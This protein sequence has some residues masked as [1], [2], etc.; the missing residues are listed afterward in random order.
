MTTDNRDKDTV[1]FEHP[2]Y[3]DNLEYWHRCRVITQGSDAV[4]RGGETFLPRLKGQKGSMYEAYKG[5]AL[6]FEASARTVQGILGALCSKEPRLE[7]P[8]GNTDFFE[9][10]VPYQT[11]IKSFIKKVAEELIIVGRC[12]LFLDA[13][14]EGQPYLAFYEAESIINWR[15]I[16][17]DSNEI[18]T[19]VVLREEYD[20]PLQ[21]FSE[22]RIR[23]RVLQLDD[24]GNYTQKVYIKK[25]NATNRDAFILQ[26]E[27]IPKRSGQPL[28][29]IPFFF[30]NSTGTTTEVSLPPIIGLVNVNI[31]HYKSSADIEHARHF[32]ALPTLLVWGFE[33]E[34]ASDFYIGSEVAWVTESK[35]A[36]AKFLEYTGGGLT[37]LRL[38]LETKEQMMVVLGANLLAAP[39]PA[40]ESADNQKLKRSG[41][42]HVIANIADS[43]GEGMT[44]AL[45]ALADWRVIASF[46]TIEIEIN[47]QYMQA[48]PDAA[49]I[50]QLVS[51]LQSGAMSWETFQYNLNAQGLI[52]DGLT[53]DEEREQIESGEFS[54]VQPSESESEG[55]EPVAEPEVEDTPDVVDDGDD[56]G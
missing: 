35:D 32:T 42:N 17:V 46:D 37:E 51:L 41:E 22:K 38:A 56:D 27:I 1:D 9:S 54:Q 19:L 11:P 3:V 7:P 36:G 44:L 39:K 5:R 16:I 34:N 24:G 25:E 2:E 8:G 49:L 14:E 40:S 29:Y 23:Y 6:F 28:K 48:T 15:T 12:G 45:K 31:S 21:F 52:P 26:S 33:N 10:V 43:L 13:P 53:P 47:K 55:T 50:G 4:K 30:I 18:L 20:E